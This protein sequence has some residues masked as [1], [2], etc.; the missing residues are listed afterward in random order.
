MNLTVALAALPYIPGNPRYLLFSDGPIPVFLARALDRRAPGGSR[1][2]R[3]SPS[4]RGLAGPGLP[5]LRSDAEWRGFVRA[6]EARGGP[7]VLHG[8]LPRDQGQLPLGGAHRR[9]PRSSAPPPPSTSSTTAT[10][11]EA[12]PRPPYRGE[13]HGGGEA[14]AAPRAARRGLRAAR[15]DEAGPPACPRKVDPGAVSGP[16]VPVEILPSLDRPVGA[17]VLMGFLS[18]PVPNSRSRSTGSA[19]CRV[20][21]NLRRLR[22]PRAS[23]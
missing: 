3:S 7:L 10:R 21:A 15:P 13:R 9:A 20:G 2:P 6:L 17:L 22:G 5:A 11:V 18:G 19:R 1:W 16:R 4:G 23:R 14:G 8:L 12:A